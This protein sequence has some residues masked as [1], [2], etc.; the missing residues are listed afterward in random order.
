MK[1][2]K[3]EKLFF[4]ELERVAIVSVACKVVGLSR[5]SVYR[6]MKEDEKFDQ[7]VQ[8]A[9]RMGIESICDL[10]E[11]KLVSNINAGNQ[12][13][14][15]FVLINHRRVYYKPKLP[16]SPES[17]KLTPIQSIEFIEIDKIDKRQY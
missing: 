13:A 7:K 2:A 1:K 8:N 12:R 5:Q 3:L 4:E 17:H 6:W 11:S 10:A 9:L 16:I 14:I 15:E